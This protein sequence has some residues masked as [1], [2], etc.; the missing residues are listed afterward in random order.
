MFKRYFRLLFLLLLPAGVSAQSLS[1]SVQGNTSG[2][3]ASTFSLNDSQIAMSG[4]QVRFLNYDTA[5]GQFLA[6]GVAPDNSLIGFLSNKDK[7]ST[8]FVTDS[9]GDTLSQFEVTSLGANDP[10]VNIYPFN[11]GGVLVRDNIASFSFY[12]SFG[13]IITRVSNSSQSQGGEAISEVASDSHG[14]TVVIYNPQIKRNGNLG[15]RAQLLNEKHELEFIYSDS[16]KTINEVTVSDDGQFIVI[17]SGSGSGN[18]EAVIFDRFG[19]EV[20]TISTDEQVKGA[21]LSS[22]AGY[23][24]LFTDGRVLVYNTLTGERKG[25]ASLRAPVV[26]AKY[27]PQDEII[28]AM[29]GSV[30]SSG[31]TINN[32]RFHAIHLGQRQIVR[33]E[34]DTGLGISDALKLSLTRSSGGQYVLEG[35][36]KKLLISAAF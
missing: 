12:D 28:L 18:S 29:T 8:A 4:Q 35:A 34:F 9:R 30:A 31:N 14:E 36:S 19:N 6:Y 10:S 23:V 2:N 32:V 15:S 17:V 20:N 25:S 22:D 21:R 13:N 27:F 11:T 26:I 33:E 1:I 7:G 16:D 5:I 24:T 3:S